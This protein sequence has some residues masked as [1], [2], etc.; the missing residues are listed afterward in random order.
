MMKKQILNI[1]KQL[2]R[3]EQ[4]QV[5]GGFGPGGDCSLDIVYNDGTTN[6]IPFDAGGQL[7][8]NTHAA[9]SA[10]Q[11]EVYPLMVVSCTLN[12]GGPS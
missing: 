7:N 4:K 9:C 6:N 8:P 3:V 11:N 10:H 12:C 5:H 1:G 2:T